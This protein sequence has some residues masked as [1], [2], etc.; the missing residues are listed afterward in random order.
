MAHKIATFRPGAWLAAALVLGFLGLFFMLP[1][2]SV[3]ANAFLEG[4]GSWTL[5]HFADE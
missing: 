2:A 1:V 4:D 3:F 5:G